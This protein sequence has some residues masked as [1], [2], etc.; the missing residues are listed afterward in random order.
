[1]R[2]IEAGYITA[3]ICPRVRSEIEVV[4]DYPE[5]R[6]KY[7]RLTDER[8]MEILQRIDTMVQMVPNPPRHVEHPRDPKD[9]PPLNLAIEVRA[10]YLISRDKDLLSLD[11]NTDFRALFDFLRVVDPVEFLTAIQPPP[12]DL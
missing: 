5:L 7:A 4:L 2:R 3:F 6:S 11:T 10:D 1:M 8:A 12:L 9:E